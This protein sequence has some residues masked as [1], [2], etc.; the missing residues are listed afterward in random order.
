MRLFPRTESHIRGVAVI[1]VMLM[2]AL[3]I[4]FTSGAAL[5]TKQNYTNSV[6]QEKVLQA[7]YAVKA[8]AATALRELTHDPTWAPTQAAPYH[9]M[10]DPA[11]GIGFDVWLEAANV[12]SDTPITT[13]DGD[14]LHKGQAV[15][16]ITP[17]VNGEKMLS[18]F[19][20][21]ENKVLLYRPPVLFDHAIFGTDT[22]E[23]LNLAPSSSYILSYDSNSG[24]PPSSPS[25]AISPINTS[26]TV[27]SL[28]GLAGRS[29]SILGEVEVPTGGPVSFT[30]GSASSGISRNDD[31]FQMPVFDVPLGSEP[32]AVPP[33]TTGIL[34]P[35]IYTTCT[36]SPG[37]TL[38]LE[39]GG[40][41]VF[42]QDLTLEGNARVTGHGDPATAG[43]ILVYAHDVLLGNGAQLNIPTTPG[44]APKPENFQFYGCS[45]YGCSQPT[46][47][48]G[49]NSK[50]S[51]VAGLGTGNFWMDNNSTLYGGVLTTGARISDNTTIYYDLAL[52]G[53]LQPGA[54]QWA[55]VS[56]GDH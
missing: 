31:L 23:P 13:P 34:P 40:V 9:E 17:I 19:A 3:I 11:H 6:H 38:Q 14:I 32:M 25:G 35:G 5:L 45:M 16:R 28:T 33:G 56:Q 47:W 53:K 2:M 1:M 42:F 37:T 8:G 46:L 4:A 24:P 22:T 50:A 51:M 55:L 48:L 21:G 44:E 7:R 49:Q 10:L 26:A 41:Y 18:S 27:R 15:I 39:Y 54:S 30:T 20:G 52:K 12:S 43:P 36:V 29:T